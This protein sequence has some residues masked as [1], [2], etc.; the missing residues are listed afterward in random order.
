MAYWDFPRSPASVNILLELAREH[1]LAER[2]CLAGTALTPDALLHAETLVSAQDE[3]RVARHLLRTLGETRGLGLA[4]GQRYHLSSYGVW[5]FTLLSSPT[6]RSAIQRGLEYI[7]LTFAF[8]RIR[9][10]AHGDDLWL[11]IDDSELPADI[12]TF[13]LERE[14][15]A[16]LTIQRELF[17]QALPLRMAGISLPEDGRR[18]AYEAVLGEIPQFGCAQSY[19]ILPGA[20]LDM[21]LP[22]A[23]P[24]TA[25]YCEQQCQALLQRHRA[26]GGVAGQVRDLL[27]REH[28]LPDMARV[29]ELMN[30]SLR[31]LHRR[32]EAEQTSF[33]NLLDEVR[34]A[35][36][37]ELLASGRLGIAHV[38]DRLGYAEPAS[39]LRAFTRWTGTTPAQWQRRHAAGTKFHHSR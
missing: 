35:L 19:A 30:M 15:A 36:A 39:F 17:A 37:Q 20:V 33:R 9:P 29:A 10:E 22:Q 26:R 4:A 12:R 6:L 16:I 32:L 21:P 34:A 5:G 13:M 28:L 8:C 31:T 3:L 1:G 18:T 27:L 2:D 11:V 24:V 38:A 14:L 7:E 23:N 25:R